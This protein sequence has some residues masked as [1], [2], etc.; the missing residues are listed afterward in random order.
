MAS[1]VEVE[2]CA[3]DAFNAV[4][5][6]DIIIV[7]DVLRC[8]SSIIHAF[9]NGAKKIIPA[10]TLNEARIL[11]GKHPECLIAGERKGLRPK[12]FDLGNSPLEFSQKKVHGRTLIFTTTSGTAALARA[13]SAKWVFLG[14]FLNAQ[15]VA[16]K[17]AEIAQ[18]EAL[19]IS[20]V[21]AGKEGHFSLED[22]LCAGAIIERLHPNTLK[23]SDAASAALL[24]FKQADHNLYETIV[25]GEHARH[26]LQLGFGQDVRFSC[27]VDLFKVIPFYRNGALTLLKPAF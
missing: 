13:K 25:A 4:R 1:K 22:L 20:L 12:G 10:R 27:Q 8:S 2:I 19:G 7:I 16:S 6:G 26:L 14:G 24:A 3:R 21:L 5:R 11:R 17:T 15:S 23:L 18:Q 9:A